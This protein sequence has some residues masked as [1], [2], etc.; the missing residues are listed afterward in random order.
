[1]NTVFFLGTAL[2]YHNRSK[3]STDSHKYLKALRN[4]AQTFMYRPETPGEIEKHQ[5]QIK[6]TP[7]E[8][9]QREFLR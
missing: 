1:M 3:D 2:R 8:T 4:S 6:V 5:I 7:K 9:Y